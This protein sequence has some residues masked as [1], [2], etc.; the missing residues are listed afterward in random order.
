M[1]RENMTMP[2]ALMDLLCERYFPGRREEGYTFQKALLTVMQLVG[3]RVC[4]YT[5]IMVF[6]RTRRGVVPITDFLNMKRLKKGMTWWESFSRSGKW[7]QI[8]AITLVLGKAARLKSLTLVPVAVS[9]F[10]ANFFK[11]KISKYPS[12]LLPVTI[13]TNCSPLSMD[14]AVQFRC[15]SKF[16]RVVNG[17]QDVGLGTYGLLDIDKNRSEN[18]LRRP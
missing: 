2:D 7:P 12:A 13:N 9:L 14:E 10:F 18:Q 11:I 1:D 3:I 4:F 5:Q 17:E 15:M 8:A 6:V 16:V